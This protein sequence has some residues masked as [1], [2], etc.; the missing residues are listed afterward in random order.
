MGVWGWIILYV[1]LFALLQLLI[2]R[3]LRS[4]EDAS[5]FHST[6]PNRDPA[7]VEEFGDLDD[8]TIRDDRSRSDD[9][10]VVVCPRCGTENGT[11]FTYCRNCV[12]P[13]TVR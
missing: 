7:A 6:P 3:Y 5:L 10:S 1:L 9:P 13:M 4:D 8:R 2:Y 12:R 11:G